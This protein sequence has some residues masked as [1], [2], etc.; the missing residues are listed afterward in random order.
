MK[1]WA[2]LADIAV[3]QTPD[4]LCVNGAYPLKKHGV[5]DSGAQ[6]WVYVIQVILYVLSHIR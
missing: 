2:N 1:T 5:V 6:G 4:K 3:L